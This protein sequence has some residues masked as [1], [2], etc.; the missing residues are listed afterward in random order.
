MGTKRQRK[1]APY[2]QTHL[3]FNAVTGQYASLTGELG[4]SPYCV[5]MQVAAED[6]YDD[7]V[8]CRGFDTRMLVFVD[9]EA[10]NP[11]KP[12]ISVAKPYGG[13]KAGVY[14]IGEIYPALLPVQGN[15]TYTPPSPTEISLRLGQNPGVADGAPVG[16]QPAN[17]TDPVTLLYDH[18]GVAVN[19]LLIDRGGASVCDGVPA[20]GP[21]KAICGASI[22]PG[23]TGPIQIYGGDLCEVMTIDAEN[24]S[25]CTFRLGDRISAFVD[26]CCAPWFTGCS[27]CGSETPPDCCDRSAA[28]CVGGVEKIVAFDGGVE[29]WD[30]SE[31]C[32][33]PGAT[34]EVE[35]TCVAEVPT[36]N[37]T[38][39]CDA[40]VTTG[41]IDLS[42]LCSDDPVEILD[43]LTVPC[44][45]LLSDRWANFTDECDPCD[46][47]PPCECCL[48]MVPWTIAECDKSEVPGTVDD[49]GLTAVT[50]SNDPVC[51][52][53]NTTVTLTFTNNSGGD[54]GGGGD[55]I[56]VDLGSNIVS[57]YPTCTAASD[58]GAITPDL[59]GKGFS[60]EWPMPGTW[61]NGATI[62]RTFTMLNN[63]CTPGVSE[64]YAQ[65]YAGR[66][67]ICSIVWNGVACP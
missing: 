42:A 58:S 1:I 43:Q 30:V 20:P 8:I 37:W 39:T 16:G 63:G 36:A 50:S 34:F 48:E 45:G 22:A 7:Y 61:A 54:Y 41:S 33:C 32:G 27:C 52:G 13:R 15:A 66:G 65:V 67:Y 4:V 59:V 6:T 47:L 53:E 38:Y 26:K 14:E 9:Y 57:N 55:P 5:L 31:C 17:L 49:V 23:E 21:Y 18:N 19:W 10:D 56:R 51:D 40:T 25:E 3:P 44:D 29:A 62:V 2:F 35:I 28:I 60:V 46:I 24:H 11:D 64:V 12:G